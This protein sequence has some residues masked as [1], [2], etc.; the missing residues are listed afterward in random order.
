[1][2][3]TGTI[4]CSTM[5]ATF[6]Q[7]LEKFF[8]SAPAFDDNENVTND[9]CDESFGFQPTNKQKIQIF[10]LE[11]QLKA[12]SFQSTFQDESQAT[13]MFSMNLNKNYSKSGND[14]VGIISVY[15]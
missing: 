4:M 14:T 7:D 15:T 13:K 12:N 3:K 1:M 11:S 6:S 8:S 10:Q 9:N 2:E 5:R